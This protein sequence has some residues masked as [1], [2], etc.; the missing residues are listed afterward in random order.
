MT[1]VSP[2]YRRYWVFGML[3]VASWCVM[4]FTHEVGH[5][6]G[7]WVSGGT[8]S[9][10]DL[11]PWRMPYSFFD[12]NPHPLFT[13]WCGPMFGVIGPALTGMIIR[14]KWSWFIADFCILAN[15][16][17]IATAWLSGDHY[18]D[19]AKLLEHGAHPVSILVFCIVTIGIGYFRFRRDCIGVLTW[20]E[21]VGL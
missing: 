2:Q 8:L 5:I 6:F 18:L 1:G 15:G 20:N 13:L 4:T 11:V 3:L 14:K 10:A 7:G 21:D 17:Y 16:M 19:T 9:Q 12:P